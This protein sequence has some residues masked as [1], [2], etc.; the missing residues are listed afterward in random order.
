L[1]L[2]ALTLA[3]PSANV[4]ASVL[5]AAPLADLIRQMKAVMPAQWFPATSP[6]QPTATP[7]LDGLL[8]GVATCYLWLQTLIAYANLQTRLTTMTDVFLDLTALDFFGAAVARRPK[9]SDFNYR[10]RIQWELNAPKVTRAAVIDRLTLLTGRAPIVD[11]PA[12]TQDNGSYG[13]MDTT[14]SS[15][16]FY[17]AGPG[18]YGS[19]GYPRQV[20]ITAYRPNGSA[21]LATGS[22][23]DA[24]IYACV[25]NAM[26]LATIGWLAISN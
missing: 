20:F 9:E 19:L 1:R 25:A 12:S 8:S 26:P 11:E 3:R 6:G 7:V 21:G 18:K 14:A 17:G 22:V 2:N 13:D 10:P 16:A 5:V 4:A 15:F 24:E 23:P